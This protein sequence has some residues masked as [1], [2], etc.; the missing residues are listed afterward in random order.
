MPISYEEVI[1]QIKDRLD[2]LEVVSERV[3]LKKSGSHYWGLCPFHKEKT[4]S[5]SV[6]PSLGI[7]KCFSCGEGGDALSFLMKIEGKS[8]MEVIRDLAEKFGYELPATGGGSS[9]G[10]RELKEQM[11]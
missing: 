6:N 8:F 5:F 1:S 9:A 7:Y 10:M 4:P 11:I 2:I 3:I